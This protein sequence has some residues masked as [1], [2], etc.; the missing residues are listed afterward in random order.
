MI[1]VKHTRFTSCVLLRDILLATIKEKMLA[2]CKKL[3]L[4][5][6]P[7]LKKDVTAQRMADELIH[8]PL[9][10]L[11][12]LSKAGLRLVDEFVNAGADKY[13]VCKRRKTEYK[14]Q[15]YGLVLTY[16]DDAN[17]QWHLLMPDQVRESLAQSYKAYLNFAEKGIK[18]PTPKDFRFMSMLDALSGDGGKERCQIKARILVKLTINMFI[19][20]IKGIEYV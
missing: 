18:A 12:K 2:I 1:T 4:S 9:N 20:M 7:N 17:D 16:E 5:V 19:C 8:N 15:Q 10:I 6:S 11:C 14:L 3:D 13:V